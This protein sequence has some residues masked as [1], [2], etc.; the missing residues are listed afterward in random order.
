MINSGQLINGLHGSDFK[1][2][3]IF[4]SKK[5]DFY[6]ILSKKIKYELPSLLISNDVY[7]DL[8]EKLQENFYPSEIIRKSENNGHDKY[9]LLYRQYIDFSQ[10]KYLE[11]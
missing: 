6:E 9:E 1:L 3:E 10:I 4:L 8:S 2:D 5:L 11:A 7:S